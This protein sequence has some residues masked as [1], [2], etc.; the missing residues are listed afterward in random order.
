LAVLE[1]RS[2]PPNSLSTLKLLFLARVLKGEEMI[3]VG[4]RRQPS[5]LLAHL[6]GSVRVSHQVHFA[7]Q[8]VAM[9]G[10]VDTQDA[11]DRVPVGVAVGVSCTTLD[12]GHLGVNLLEELQGVGVHGAVVGHLESFSLQVDTPGQE[13]LFDL[14]GGVPGEQEL[15]LSQGD[16]EDH[17]EVV[18]IDAQRGG[19]GAASGQEFSDFLGGL[20]SVGT[21]QGIDCLIEQVLAPGVEY[22]DGQLRIPVELTLVSL[23]IGNSLAAEFLLEAVIGGGFYV[24]SVEDLGHGNLVHQPEESAKM[25]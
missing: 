1:A 11:T 5:P 14:F 21:E 4:R 13:S 22:L 25:I 23:T 3:A 20:V 19:A 8:V 17:R 24:Y 10:G 16:P 9:D 7:F 18:E 15:E 2:L 12:E 6:K